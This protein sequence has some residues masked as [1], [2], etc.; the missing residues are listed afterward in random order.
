MNDGLFHTLS[1][2]NIMRDAQIT[3]NFPGDDSD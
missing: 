3:G 1:N 2:S